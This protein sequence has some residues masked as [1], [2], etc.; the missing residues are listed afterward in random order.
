M[1]FGEY[2]VR[3]D[4]AFRGPISSPNTSKLTL[5]DLERAVAN[6]EPAF[7]PNDAHEFEELRLMNER[8]RVFW[9][10]GAR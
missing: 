7:G 10:R 3:G 8:N 9:K 5:A 2:R 6:S 1:R 4:G